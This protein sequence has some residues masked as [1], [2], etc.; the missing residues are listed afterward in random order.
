VFINTSYGTLSYSFSVLVTEDAAGGDLGKSAVALAFSLALLVSGV[1][2]IFTGTVAD[3]LGCRR[4]LSIGSVLGAAALVL[5]AMCDQPWQATLVLALAMGP[6]MAATFYEPVYVL[7]NRW[8]AAAERPRAYGVLTLLSGVSITIFTPLTHGLVEA[9]GWREG[10][11]VL[12]GIL[13]G[14]GV[15]VPP[16]L[17]EPPPEAPAARP[18]G[19]ITELW[20]GFRHM[21]PRF[22]AFSAAF[23]VATAAFSGFSFHMVS[24]LETRG[25]AAGPVAAAI[26]IT[27]LVSLPLRFFLPTLSARVSATAMLTVCLGLLGLSAVLASFADSWWQVWV[28]VGLF[29]SVFGT[30]YPLR[31]LVASEHFAGPFYGRILGIQALLVAVGRAAGPAVIGAIG[32]TASAYESGFRIAAVVLLCAAV[33]MVVVLPPRYRARAVTAP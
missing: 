8:F 11:M 4:P 3:T 18:A 33:A 23:F 14:V 27:G 9:M 28:Y 15:V 13:L 17:S 24:Q 31:A 22:W 1:A 25:F 2:A 26:G 32:T 19:F 20:G 5:F 6:A 30:I 16:L 10:V 29:G 12:A 21:T 7:M